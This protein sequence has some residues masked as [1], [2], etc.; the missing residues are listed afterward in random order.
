MA[1]LK[2]CVASTNPVKI[3][4]ARRA[5]SRAYPN[6]TLDI[7]ARSVPSGVSDQPMTDFETRK[8]HSFFIY[9]FTTVHDTDL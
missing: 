8:V 6:V 4:S 9:S 2:V 3:E 7:V 1:A 5:V